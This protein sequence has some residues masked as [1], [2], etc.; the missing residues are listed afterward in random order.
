MST[1]LTPEILSTLEK[2]SIEVPSWA[3]GNSGTRFKVF[4]TPGT[5][6][7]PF[8]KIADAAEVNRLTGLAPAVALHI[9]W[10]LVDDFS[11]L[12]AHA[13][14]LGVQLGTV[15]SNT[16]QDDDYKFGALTHEDA[17]IRRK[18]IDHHL[19]CVDV[20]DE[21]GSRDLKIW[22]AEG[23]NYPGQADMRGRQD[24][25]QESLQ[26]IY[27]RLS[28][29]QRLVLEYK[30]FEPAF[31]HTDVP[32]W[33]TSYAQVAALG[34]KAMVCLDTGHHAP[35]TNIEFIVMQLL[36]LGKLGSFDFNSRFYADDDLIVGAADPFQ[37]FRIL[38]EVV[39]GDGL[40]NPDVSFMLDQCHNVEEKIPGQIR[41]VLNVQEMTARALLL[42]RD[43]LGAA[44]RSGDVLGANAIMMD[45]FYTDVRPALAE[46]RE[47]RGL[48]ADPM[49]AYAAS[50]YQAK[51]NADRVGGAQASWGA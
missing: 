34:E 1:Q 29:D 7:D 38:V 37:L 48:P 11:K 28:D 16:F 25:L 33:G 30:F 13:E 2:Q 47:S 12:R 19:Q 3:Y 5:P 44:Q 45:A 9:P 39:R 22:L 17:A 6:R 31:Y 35:G 42:D 51:I 4:G 32:D 21:T 8:E 24:R 26:E 36:R 49:A 23:S 14:D 50:G 43:A 10:D 40:N 15:N 18:A 46:W 20:M 27:A 41:S